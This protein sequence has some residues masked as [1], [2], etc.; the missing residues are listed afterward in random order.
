MAKFKI[1]PVSETV[2]Q[3]HFMCPGCN[4]THA[5]DYSWKFNNDLEKPTVNPSV[6]LNGWL[7]EKYPNGTCHSFI[8]DGK[9]SFLSDCSHELKGKTVYL[10]DIN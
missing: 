8:R 10:L 1:V 4:T 7:N 2:N 5:I 6:L 3:L 9:I